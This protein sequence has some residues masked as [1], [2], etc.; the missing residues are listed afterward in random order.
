MKKKTIII[1]SIIILAIL[2]NIWILTQPKPLGNINYSAAKPATDSSNITFPGKTGEKIKF[3]FA[4]NIKSGNL[5]ITLSD[6]TGNIVYE[7]DKA[8]KLT[9]YYTLESTDT[10]KLSANYSGFTGYF[11]IKFYSAK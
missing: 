7:L 10:Y 8:R 2:A 5:D 3:S 11:K 4:S 6:S 1:S 9:A